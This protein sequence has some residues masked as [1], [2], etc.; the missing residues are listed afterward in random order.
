M[1]GTCIC[2]S[3]FVLSFV[4]LLNANSRISACKMPSAANN[5]LIFIIH[6][7]KLRISKIKF[8]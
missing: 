4:R 1:N 3:S 7:L 6:E 5:E 8:V 2:L